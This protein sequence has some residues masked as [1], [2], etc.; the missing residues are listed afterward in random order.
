MLKKYFFRMF[1]VIKRVIIAP[2]KV[3]NLKI[4]K[5]GGKKVNYQ[6]I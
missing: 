4:E 6:T 1:Q 3:V 2:Q 5:I